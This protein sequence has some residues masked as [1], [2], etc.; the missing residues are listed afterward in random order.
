MNSA[1]HHV[2][3]HFYSFDVL[4]G[5]AAFVIALYHWQHFYITGTAPLSP[6]I[7]TTLPLYHVFAF[8]Y[9]EGFLAVDLF[10]M[11]SGFIFFWLYADKIAQRKITAYAFSV[12]RL[13]RLYPLHF[14][15]L[16][17]VACLQWYQWRHTGAYF[18]YPFNDVY[19]FVLQLFFV[20]SWGLEHGPSF[21]GPAWSISV[22]VFLYTVFFICCGL[23]LL[24]T[25]WL[26]LLA[27]AGILL[28][29]FYA[30]LGQG[31]F[32]FFTGGL[33]YYTYLW[34]LRRGRTGWYARI[35]MLM[36]GAGMIIAGWVY[37]YPEVWHS[38]LPVSSTQLVRVICC[39]GLFPL[40][41]LSLALWETGS[42]PFPARLQLIGDCS[43]ACYLLHFPL[44]LLLLQL[45]EAAGFGRELFHSPYTMAVYMLLLIPLSLGTYHYF[46]Y[47][48]QQA[49]RK[50]FLPPKPLPY[51]VKQV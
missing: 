17:L 48:A 2:P 28:C 27:A 49:L 35:G 37:Y 15:T 1:I 14:A 16:L 11:L 32:A 50:R 47:P 5:V 44:Q 30:P 43:Y 13:S 23:R 41:I 42:R 46:E 4:R 31:L 26:L 9:E 29:F 10:F 12:I 6:D 7:K 38:L 20:N 40:G 45:A 51:P 39:I 18:I 24:R 33:A 19:H 3:R 8:F 36:T 21:N 22:E 25:G 34:L